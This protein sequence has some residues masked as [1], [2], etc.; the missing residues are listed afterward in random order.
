ML[1]STACPDWERRIVAGE[2]LIPFAPLFPA[3]AESALEVF[4]SLRL[5]DVAGQPTMGECSRPWIRDLAG[6]VFGAYD[7][8]EGRRLIRE[9]FLLIS[10]KNTKSTSAAGIMLTALIR[11]WRHSGE[12]LIVAPT[13]EVANNSFQPARDMIRAD[14]ELG[15]LLHVHEHIR[16]IRHRTTG[17]TLKVVAADS[18]AVGGKKTIGLFVD[19]L[20]LFGKK[21]DAESKL[22]EAMGGLASRP[23]GFV[24]YA[25]TQSDDPPAGVFAQKLLYARHVRDGIVVDPQ[26]LPVLYEFPQAMLDA[27][28][29]LDPANFYVTNPNLGASVDA[30]FLAREL[31]KAQV[32]G[33]ASLKGLLAKHLNVEVGQGLRSDRWAGADF[34]QIASMAPGLT[35]AQ[36][37]ERC[38]VAVVGIDGGGLDDLLGVAVMGRERETRRWL[39]WTHAWAHPIVLEKRKEIAP[40]LLDFEKDGDLTLVRKIGEDVKGVAD[41]CAQVRTAGLLPDE[42]AI[43]VDAAGINDIVNELY[44]PA[45]A[46]TEQQIVA[47]SQGWKLNA[48]IKTTERQIAGLELIHGGS[49]LMAWSVSNARLN[50]VGNAVSITKQKS[51]SAKIDPLMATFNAVSLMSTNPAARKVGLSFF[52]M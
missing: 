46:F 32:E 31:R 3:E 41:V 42:N 18:E 15:E 44:G 27:E 43:G 47:I 14:P 51:G 10:K 49:R 39:L 34:W 40:R 24:I 36:L 30:D 22:R 1:W 45:R 4:D 37:L 33:E 38:E 9:V 7:P 28:E 16:T 50:L 26:F 25:T 29:H 48:A 23:E 11:N 17:A 5:V 35:L 13:V 12:F 20:Y 19:E 8:D 21:P 52:F 2:S 6:A